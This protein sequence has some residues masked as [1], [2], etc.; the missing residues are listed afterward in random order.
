MY[1]DLVRKKK[2]A[3]CKVEKTLEH[4]YKRTIS[5]DGF[6]VYCRDCDNIKSIKYRTKFAEKIR[7]QRKSFREANKKR[8][9][10]SKNRAKLK[11]TVEQFDAMLAERD[12]RCEMCGK[13]Q[14]E[15]DRRICIDHCHKTGIVRG[16]LCDTCNRGLGLL[17]D[18]TSLLA[19]GILYLD[20]YKK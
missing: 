13:H 17:K 15:M 12:G 10:V 7:T 14:S 5:P 2:C 19:R 8:L 6:G 11:I 18:D 4:F 20:K 1:A 3:W 16:L 9:S